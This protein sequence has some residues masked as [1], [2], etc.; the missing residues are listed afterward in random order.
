M[1]FQQ[2][3]IENQVLNDARSMSPPSN[4]DLSSGGSPPLHHLQVPTNMSSPPISGG[5]DDE[6]IPTAIVI[7]NIPFNVRRETLLDIIVRVM[8][9]PL[10]VTPSLFF[11]LSRL[12]SELA[13]NP[14]ISFIHSAHRPRSTSRHPTLSTTTLTRRV[15]FADWRL[16]TFA[17]PQMLMPSSSR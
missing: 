9:A 2:Q 14:G 5:G 6:V 12:G 16:P 17:R 10:F 7:K 15:P 11:L 3:W 1:A 13:T 4:S 8:T